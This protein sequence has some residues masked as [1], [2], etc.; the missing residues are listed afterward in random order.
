MPARSLC[1]RFRSIFT[2]S[3]N[4]HIIAK[5][6]L[7]Y[8]GKSKSRASHKFR[9]IVILISL[10][11]FPKHLLFFPVTPVTICFQPVLIQSYFGFDVCAQKEYYI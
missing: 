3:I 7:F 11:H 6:R 1:F 9:E 10:S 5:E 4:L 8:D 2:I